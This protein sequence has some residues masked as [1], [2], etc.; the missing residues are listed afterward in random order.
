MSE[1]LTTIEDVKRQLGIRPTDSVDDAWLA[2]AIESVSA[3]IETETGTWLAPRTATTMIL[4]GAA[5]EDGWLLRT[6][7]G[8]DAVTYVGVATTDQPDD[9]SGTYT[10]ITSGVY[11][12]GRRYPDWPA[13]RIELSTIAGR[14]FPLTGYAVTKVTGDWGFAEV[15]PR[16]AEIAT[17]AVVRAFR[18]RSDGNPDVAIAGMDGAV[19]ILRR[20][21][22]AEMDEL[23]RTYALESR[24]AWASVGI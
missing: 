1:G 20:I 13:M 11:L 2:K 17:I 22:P 5:A 24:P 7:L 21:A 23:L 4:D 12:R 19:R 18:A 16:V 10:Q 15:P 6:P 3:A 9:G 8:L 14:R